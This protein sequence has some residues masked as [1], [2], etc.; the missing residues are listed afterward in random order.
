MEQKEDQHRTDAEKQERDAILAGPRIKAVALGAAAL[1]KLLLAHA[2]IRTDEQ[3]AAGGATMPISVAPIRLT[4]AGR[5]LRLSGW[6]SW[7]LSQ[8]FFLAVKAFY[9]KRLVELNCA[10][11]TTL[12]PELRSTTIA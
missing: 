7:R 9:L 4:R 1:A 11:R 8:A 6:A 2:M 5:S 10:P 3:P 12:R